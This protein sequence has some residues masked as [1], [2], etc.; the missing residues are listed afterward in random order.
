MVSLTCLVLRRSALADSAWECREAALV[1]LRETAVVGDQEVLQ[2]AVAGLEDVRWEVREAAVRVLQTVG[3]IG[4]E[5]LVVR[6]SSPAPA[7]PRERAAG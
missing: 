4:D 2:A 7:R 6:P 1:L 3:V 5:Q